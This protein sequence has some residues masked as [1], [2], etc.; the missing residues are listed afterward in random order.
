MSFADVAFPASQVTWRNKTSATLY[1]YFVVVP[2]GITPSCK[3]FDSAG[4]FHSGASWSYSVEAGNSG[5]FKFQN[6]P[7]PCGA[8][9]YETVVLGVPEYSTLTE[10]I[11]EKHL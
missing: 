9:K 7:D 8:G 5:W 1:V 3:Q 6:S 4:L 2:T 10:D 11:T